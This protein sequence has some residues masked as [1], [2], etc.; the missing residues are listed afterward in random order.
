MTPGATAEG[1]SEARFSRE[2]LAGYDP[3]V[4]GDATVLVVGAGA[5]A[6][7][8]LINLALSGVGEL[9]IV[10][11]DEFE[12]H[13]APRS[14]LY[15][16]AEER[17]KLGMMKARVAATKTLGFMRAP[18]ARVRFA[19]SPVQ[20]L[21]SGAFDGVDVVAACVDNPEARSYLGDM[22]RL[23]GVALVEG[24][25][26]AAQVSLS[27]FPPSLRGDAATDP[28]YRCGHADVVGTFSCQR[29]AGEAIRAGVI[30][31]IQSAAATLGGLQAEAILQAL[32]GSHAGCRRINLDIRTGRARAYELTLDPECQGVHRRFSTPTTALSCTGE[33]TLGTL[34]DELEVALGPGCVVD[35]REGLVCEAY[36]DGCGRLVRAAV[37]DWAWRARPLCVA[38]GGPHERYGADA[39]GLTPV[40][41]MHLASDMP[42]GLRAV[43]CRQA[44]IPALS[45]LEAR[46]ANGGPETGFQL[47]GAID[48]LFESTSHQRLFSAP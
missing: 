47:A 44:G 37:P 8:V 12:D 17:S 2:R 18:R 10:D 27:C 41:V 32:H 21:G 48:E 43:S 16:T 36:C 38:C 29:Y 33:D 24:G 9:R 19:V 22:S 31:A 45:R 11:F 3:A 46:P 7:N 35:L 40:I 42:A 6:Q 20:A 34:V 1:A 4:V 13:N 30:P 5:L 25:F 15:P 28:C 23:L 26:H 39:D 14:P